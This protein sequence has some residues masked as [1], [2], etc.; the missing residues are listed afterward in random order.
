[1]GL[2]IDAT[3]SAAR[4]LVPGA[5]AEVYGVA[6]PLR[7][8]GAAEVH[9]ALVA[10][11][12]G[13]PGSGKPLAA[14][15]ITPETR[16]GWHEALFAG[17]VKLGAAGAWLVVQAKTGAVEWTGAAEAASAAT[18]TLGAA[19][20]AR[21]AP[22]PVAVVAQARLLRKPF[23]TENTPLSRWAGARRARR[24]TPVRRSS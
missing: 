15:V 8:S 9:V 18:R 13:A 24:S 2:K 19:A 22:F 3:F 20:S 11:D 6:L 4:L 12:G 17:P 7:V 21:W 23:A 1:M 16:D 14:T 10:D 5:D